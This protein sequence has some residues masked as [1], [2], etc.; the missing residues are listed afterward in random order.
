MQLRSI[1]ISLIFIVVHVVS[2]G[3]ERPHLD[4]RKTRSKA[5]EVSRYNRKHHLNNKYCLLADMGLPSGMKRFVVWDFAKNDTLFTGLVS[6]GCGSGPWSGMW[7]KDKPAFSD[8]PNSHCT[9]LGKYK[10]G[11]RA[12]SQW[13]V[14][15]KYLLSGLETSNKNAMRRQVVFHS[16]NQVSDA[17][18]YPNGTPEGWGCPAISNNTMIKVDA[19]LRKQT[20]PVLLW[21]YH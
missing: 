1:V 5:L 12:Y 2:S 19:L 9:A 11:A 16:W 4:I 20:T 14:H 7:S 18:P 3:A 17:E 15:I 21:I 13:G 8:A 10:I 6:H